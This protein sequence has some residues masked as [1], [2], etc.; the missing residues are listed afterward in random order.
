M[1]NI[2]NKH[3][4]KDTGMR[5]TPFLLAIIMLAGCSVGPDYVKPTMQ[6][7]TAFKEQNGWVT[8]QPQDTLP[9]GKWWELFGD[10]DLNALVEQVEISNQNIKV[11]EAQYRQAQADRKST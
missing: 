1:N 8:A 11:A 9:K 4:T 10:A 2:Q 3:I 6:I 7:P 5:I